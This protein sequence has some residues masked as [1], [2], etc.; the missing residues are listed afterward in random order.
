MDCSK[1]VFSNMKVF[2]IFHE[3]SQP[4]LYTS[5]LSSNFPHKLLA[6]KTAELQDT[7][8]SVNFKSSASITATIASPARSHQIR[9]YS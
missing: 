1:N 8:L 5:L 9:L 3:A 7:P 2:A 6:Y 4:V